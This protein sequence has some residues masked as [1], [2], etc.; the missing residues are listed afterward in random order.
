MR[1]RIRSR[2]TPRITPSPRT[3]LRLRRHEN[4]SGVRVV[5]GAAVQLIQLLQLLSARRARAAFISS[6]AKV[7]PVVEVDCCRR[8][9]HTNSR[10]SRTS[11]RV[12]RV[13]VAVV[14][15]GGGGEG[16]V[17]SVDP[18]T[19]QVR[20]MHLT[21]E[22]DEELKRL[23]DREEQLMGSTH[24]IREMSP[25]VAALMQHP[26]QPYIGSTTKKSKG[27]GGG[28][29]TKGFGGGATK[30]FGKSGQR[31]KGG[32]RSEPSSSS[33]SGEQPFVHFGDSKWTDMEQSY[34]HSLA[35]D[36]LVCIE[37]VLPD[38]L[39]DR[40]REYLI[41]LRDRS[42]SAIEAGA[43]TN[44]QDRFADVLLNQ[45]RCDLKVPLGPAAV[46][47]ALRHLLAAVP[48]GT[49]L[50]NLIELVYEK[51]GSVGSQAALYELNCFMSQSGA[52]RQLVH[53]DIVSQ[54]DDDRPSILGPDEPIMLTCFVALQDVD[55]SMGPTYFIP[56]THNLQAH[57]QFFETP[58]AV[59]PAPMFDSTK[60]ELLGTRPAVMGTLKKGSCILFDPRTLHCAGANF[61]DDPAK[62]RA[63]FYFSFKNPKVDSPGCPSCGGYG[64]PDAEF[65]LQQLCEELLAETKG[66][67]S[68][69]RKLAM[70]ASNP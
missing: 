62:T 46:N 45:N 17:V 52:R 58:D 11:L 24:P 57:R 70:L 61:C 19:R 41:D 8:V 7:L 67:V 38:D 12:H 48:R 39:A 42:R 14:G 65:T 29:A 34:A 10:P 43:I 40:L 55:A 6:N 1:H 16:G 21:K 22:Q 59:P 33:N 68:A 32:T 44:S 15:G 35:S 27:V 30:G 13:D 69:F 50:R 60:D 2:I 64:I 23:G 36:G 4:G 18:E 66:D 47:D 28:G 54:S 25:A 63:L 3:R 20:F 37:N 31:E 56:G 49:V 5:L 53:A 9:L 51:H 26:P